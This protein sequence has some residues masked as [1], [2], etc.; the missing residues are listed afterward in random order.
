[1]AGHYHTFIKNF[2]S[3]ASPL[4]RLLN[5][6]VLF[7]WHEPQQDSFDALKHALIHTSVLAFPD[8][9]LPF[10]MCTDASALGTGTVLMQSVDR[11]R[12]LVIAYGSQV[13][14]DPES[15]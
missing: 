10:T 11:K 6:D 8:Y 14:T 12:P 9:Q 7:T 15:R 2:A 3:I 1:M 13:L 5:K 4:T